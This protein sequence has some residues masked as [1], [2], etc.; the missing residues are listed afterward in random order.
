MTTI[1]AVKPTPISDIPAPDYFKDPE[2]VAAWKADVT[3]M[4][5]YIKDI[6]EA[7]GYPPSY[8]EIVAHFEGTPG[9][10]STC[11]VRTRMDILKKHGLIQ[12]HP[13]KPKVWKLVVPEVQ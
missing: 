8:R 7:T 3:A 13:T 1:I 5:E 4:Y 11:S 9:L 12:V 2:K 6:Q 10:T